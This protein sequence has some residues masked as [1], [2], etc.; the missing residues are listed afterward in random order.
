[1]PEVSE[2]ASE[3]N[4]KFMS[5]F[6]D[7]KNAKFVTIFPDAKN[8]KRKNMNEKSPN[9]FSAQN[10]HKLTRNKSEIYKENCSQFGMNKK[11]LYSKMQRNDDVQILQAKIWP[12]E[13]HL[14]EVKMKRNS[15]L[16]SPRP[17]RNVIEKPISKWAAFLDS[18]EMMVNQANI[19]NPKEAQVVSKWEK[20]MI[21]DHVD[22][23]PN[24]IRDH[25]LLVESG[26][27]DDETFDMSERIHEKASVWSLKT[28]SKNLQCFDSVITTHLDDLMDVIAF[29]TDSEEVHASLL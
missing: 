18:E 6:P 5:L 11:T 13:N 12:S 20:Y 17:K 15:A 22:R 1:M 16:E 27:S 23:R 28:S 3:Y 25:D 14:E 8:L 21:S 10:S 7:A 4:K 24:T 26:N 19:E 2:N 29:S 9:K